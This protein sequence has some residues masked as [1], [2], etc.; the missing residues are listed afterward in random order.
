MNS[1]VGRLMTRDIGRSPTRSLHHPVLVIEGARGCGKT[2]VID[3]LERELAGQQIPRA[4]I[5]FEQ[6]HQATVPEVLFGVAFQ[7]ARISEPYGSFEFPLLTIG[8]L[9]MTASLSP[10]R[11]ES[12]AVLR[13]KLETKVDLADMHEVFRTSAGELAP[14]LGGA[15]MPSPVSP[16]LG[17]LAQLGVDWTMRAV[18]RAKALSP[19]WY[20]HRDQGHADDPL[21]VL[22]DLHQWAATDQMASVNELLWSAFLADL[23]NNFRSSFRAGAMTLNCVVLLD[24]ADTILGQEFVN[25]LVDAR[26]ARPAS[27]EI[28]TDPLT[29]VVT[30]RGG[31]LTAHTQRLVE[32]DASL[33]NRELT[34]DAQ[35]RPHL[36]CR[37]KLPDLDEDDTRRIVSTLRPVLPGGAVP[38]GNHQMTAML[39]GLLAGHRAS[40]G[41]F[42]AALRERPL[43]EG[44]SLALT[45]DRL[46]PGNGSQP[47][48]LED[49][50]RAQLLAGFPEEAYADL[51]T[52]AA[53]RTYQHAALLATGS[54]FLTSDLAY[55]RDIAAVLWP[56]SGGAGPAVLRRL[57]LRQ[58]ADRTG[59]GAPGWPAVFEWLRGRSQRL[60]DESGG[61]DHREDILYYTMAA[62]DIDT[63]CAAL[64]T[65]LVESGETAAGVRLLHAVAAATRRAVDPDVSPMHQVDNALAAQS[66]PDPLTRLV[67]EQSVVLDPFISNVRRTLHR[68]IAVHFDSVAGTVRGDPGPLFTAADHHHRNAELWS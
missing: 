67:I 65:E 59:G 4:R 62:G 53:A 38:I 64:R 2:G 26:R 20:G 35:R 27:G 22:V 1:L 51:V 24:N 3:E 11:P 58:L 9:A 34:F 49:K 23:R 50:L 54:G 52:C 57:L 37:Y 17:L 10:G 28:A 47:V 5:D 46:E 13:K 68:Q 63:V 7:L 16:F 15:L 32:F 29:A 18:R 12:R 61:T 36:W 33:G 31:L 41:L 30:S 42:V 44:E 45:L 21:D 60:Q 39:F 48:R 55:L 8:A 40:T 19:E 43:A 14:L 56:E 25:G 66:D 6:L